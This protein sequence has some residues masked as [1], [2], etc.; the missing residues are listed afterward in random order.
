MPLWPGKRA[1][2]TYEVGE[3]EMYKEEHDVLEGE[4]T[5]VDERDM[6]ILVH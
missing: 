4:M 1:E 3:C 2:L 5:K 6:E